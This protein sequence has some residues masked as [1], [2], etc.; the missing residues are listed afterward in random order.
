MNGHRI[1]AVG[2]FVWCVCL[3]IVLFTN[4]PYL[5]GLIL[6]VGFM[7]AICILAWGCETLEKTGEDFEISKVFTIFAKK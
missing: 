1:I 6:F 3:T 5:N 7:S 2:Y 4:N